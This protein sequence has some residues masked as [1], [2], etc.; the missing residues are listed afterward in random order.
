MAKSLNSNLDEMKAGLKEMEKSGADLNKRIDE[1][2]KSLGRFSEAFSTSSNV[3]KVM[4]KDTDILTS[5]LENVP[6]LVEF[7]LKAYTDGQKQIAEIEKKTAQ[8][9]QKKATEQAKK[10]IEIEAKKTAE[11]AKYTAASRKVYAQYF[12]DREEE[13]KKDTKLLAELKD[14][15]DEYY[16][17]MI[18]NILEVDRYTK[19]SQE[20]YKDSFAV[21]MLL[22]KDDAVATRKLL[23]D[24]SKYTDGL[25]ALMKKEEDARNKGKKGTDISYS[26][27]YI[28]VMEDDFDT[29]R[30]LYVDD[31]AE[32]QKTL[33][34]QIGFYDMLLATKKKD[35]E[36]S[37]AA[38]ELRKKRYAASLKMN[39]DNADKARKNREEESKY[40]DSLIKNISEADQYTLRS[41][42]L[43]QDSFKIKKDLYEFNQKELK[44]TQKAEIA[45]YEK[46]LK[47]MKESDKYTQ[48]SLSMQINLFALKRE[49][50]KDNADLLKEIEEKET[51]YFRKGSDRITAENRFT[52]E[53]RAFMQAKFEYLERAY[54]NDEEG[55]KSLA[56]MR[57]KYAEDYVKHLDTQIAKYGES[58]KYSEDAR[59]AHEEYFDY[60]EQLAEGEGKEE[61]RAAKLEEVKNLRLDYD[62]KYHEESAKLQADAAAESI[63]KVSEEEQKKAAEAHA[64]KVAAI[65]ALD[66][67]QKDADVE[68]MV[69]YQ[70]QLEAKVKASEDAGKKITA[71]QAGMI[72]KETNS[73]FLGLFLI[74]MGKTRENYNELKEERK[75]LIDQL[76]QDKVDIENTYTALQANLDKDSQAW[77][78]META[79]KTALANVNKQISAQQEAAVADQKTYAE[80]MIKNAQDI[81]A[82][83]T[84]YAQ[85]G[86]DI[87]KSLY[88]NNISDLEE[89]IKK[90]SELLA[91]KEAATKEHQSKLESLQK[92]AATAS[93]GRAVA[94]QEQ[95]AREMQAR[96]ES[97]AQQKELEKEKEKLEKEKEKKEKRQKRMDLMM[98]LQAAIANTAMGVTVELRKGIWGIPT[99]AIIGA[100][101]L[102]EVATI[103]KQMKKLEDGGLLRGKRHSQGGMKVEG[104]NIEVEGDEYVVNRTSTRKNLGLIEYINTQRRELS[105]DDI[106]AYYAR[107]GKSVSGMKA[108]FGAMFE[109]GGQLVNLSTV[110]SVTSVSAEAKMIDALGQI[111][112]RP[113]VSVVDITNAQQSLTQVKDIAGV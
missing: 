69:R 55:Q 103:S 59:K 46:G 28:K 64:V 36:F 85:A 91:K 99:A 100:K 48:S 16:K 12:K 101:G 35:E 83:A 113:V 76:K 112:I 87:V 73:G 7:V 58:I 18:D 84:E 42:K 77:Q 13:A 39:E 32:L 29:K 45:Y 98:Q 22:Y 67:L 80:S 26:R 74:D 44:A 21:R 43:N 17:G 93:G 53:S 72:E 70:E 108:S 111:N 102:I 52:A 107:S 86:V 78:D 49:M 30:R 60:L 25:I 104:T 8:E 96:D 62:K 20:K 79:K 105:S 63:A 40:Y 54:A 11:I 14:E 109:D 65:K 41:I 37:D 92:E 33:E 81:H 57:G 61:D 90:T 66:G 97:A 6:K 95:I 71:L 50:N 4:S 106:N 9:G 56:F 31:K 3:I 82:K 19:E 94:I 51:E 38:I 24:K 10:R 5:I 88:A 34:Q 89:D 68:E 2:I 27:E 47:A 23:E 75:K 110:D 15:K 1:S